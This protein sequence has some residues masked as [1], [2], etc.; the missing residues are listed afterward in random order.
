MEMYSDEVYERVDSILSDFGYDD[1][2]RMIVLGGMRLHGKIQGVQREHRE[3]VEHAITQV[4]KISAAPGPDLPEVGSRYR[5]VDGTERS[6]GI[7]VPWPGGNR[8]L[9]ITEVVV[10]D[11]SGREVRGYVSKP[12]TN[13]HKVE[14]ATT[15]SMFA[16]Y[17]QPDMLALPAS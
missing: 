4:I 10:G 1:A 12:E 9:T 15:L 6:H 3:A 7:V 14:Y 11:P 5:D 17:W 2:G 13:G 8:T 16:D